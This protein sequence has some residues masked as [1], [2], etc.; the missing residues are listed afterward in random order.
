M[1]TNYMHAQQPKHYTWHLEKVST[2]IT[3]EGKN[4]QLHCYRTL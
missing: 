4:V 3:K 2:H 1:H